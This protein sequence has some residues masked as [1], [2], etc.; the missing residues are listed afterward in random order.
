MSDLNVKSTLENIIN[1][2]KVNSTSK[3]N[4]NA[5]I[6]NIKS[7]TTAQPKTNTAQQSLAAIQSQKQAERS[8]FLPRQNTPIAFSDLVIQSLLAKGPTQENTYARCP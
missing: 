1:G 5:T 7:A 3:L 4:V 2:K 8:T 6:R